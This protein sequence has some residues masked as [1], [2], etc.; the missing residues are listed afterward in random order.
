MDLSELNKEIQEVSERHA[1]YADD[2][3]GVRHYLGVYELDTK[4]PYRKFVTLGAK[5]YAYEDDRG[6][7]IT[8]A[9][10]SKSGAAEMKTIDN[11]R[12]GFVFKTAGGLEARYNDLP[13]NG[14]LT[15]DGHAIKL[16]QNIYL[17]PSQY[18][19]GITM[20]YRN[21]FRLTQEQYDKYLKTR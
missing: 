6:L 15:V 3:A 18:R 17:S 11:F 20:E 10:V 7:H 12:E 13:D 4:E 19:L 16:T 2:P 1:A 14:T 8:I 21:L 5:K 9:G